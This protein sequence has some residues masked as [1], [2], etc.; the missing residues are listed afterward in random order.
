[1]CDT[2]QL[3]HLAPCI[4]FL[5]IVLL[6]AG[7]SI[8]GNLIVFTLIGRISITLTF[9]AFLYMWR[10][11]LGSNLQSSQP[12]FTSCFCAVKKWFVESLITLMRFFRFPI[13]WL[14][15]L[16]TFTTFIPLL[17]KSSSSTSSSWMLRCTLTITNLGLDL[18][19]DS[20]FFGVYNCVGEY[21]LHVFTWNETFLWS[22]FSV[23]IKKSNEF[24]TS[25]IRCF[26]SCGNFVFIVLKTAPELVLD[27]LL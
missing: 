14:T 2:P 11:L 24:G 12:I 3:A 1:M 22:L 9:Q 20:V 7:L 5:C 21:L 26:F 25:L 19:S 17:L 18:A 10:L 13:A 16:D 23:W 4:F 6:C 15:I 27:W 8:A